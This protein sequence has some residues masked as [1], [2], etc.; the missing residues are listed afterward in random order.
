MCGRNWTYPTLSIIHR[1]QV[2]ILHYLMLP[3]FVGI[4]NV[5]YHLFIRVRSRYCGRNGCYLLYHR[6]QAFNISSSV[7]GLGHQMV[8]VASFLQWHTSYI[9]IKHALLF[10]KL[11]AQP[12][13]RSV[14]NIIFFIH[15]FV[16]VFD[17]RAYLASF[18]LFLS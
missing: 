7:T 1:S 3:V 13:S 6:L 16:Y 14:K 2:N 11:F 8:L 18:G 17:S 12:E 15:T 10:G 9:Y 5:S 4:I